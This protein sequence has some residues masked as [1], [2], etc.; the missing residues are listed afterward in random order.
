MKKK[1]FIVL[2][3]LLIFAIFATSIGLISWYLVLKF[4]GGDTPN[5][6]HTHEYSVQ[7]IKEPTCTGRGYTTYVCECGK[8]YTGDYVNA[9]GHDLGDDNICTRCGYFQHEHEYEKTVINPTCTEGGYTRG[10][11][12]YCTAGFISDRTDALGHDFIDSVCTR[13]GEMSPTDGLI[14]ELSKDG[15]YYICTG[16]NPDLKSL[17]IASVYNSKP[18]KEIGSSAFDYCSLESVII[19]NGITVIGHGAF[20]CCRSLK[21]VTIPNSVTHI[22]GIAFNCCEELTE[23]NYKGTIAQWNAIEKHSSWDMDTGNYTVHCT[24]GDIAKDVEA[25]VNKDKLRYTLSDDGTYYICSGID[26]TISSIITDV[27]IAS[28]INGL[29]VKEIGASA[30]ANNQEIQYV[31]IPD[32]VGFIGNNAF[33]NCKRLTEITIPNGVERIGELAF[34]SC[35]GLTGV[36]LGNGLKYIG[37]NAFANCIS[38]TNVIIPESV[39]TIGDS[40]FTNCTTLSEVEIGNGVTSIGNAAFR[41]CN[42]KNIIIPDSVT[43]INDYAFYGCSK[44]ESITIPGGVTNFSSYTFTACPRLTDITFKGTMDKWQS[45]RGSS[46]L[47]MATTCTVHCT[48]G[49]LT[50]NKR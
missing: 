9:L 11:C 40:A 22:N 42:I 24:D 49:D 19:P 13:C 15:T 4:K 27:N 35:P 20:T 21:S 16:G 34:A 44:L 2:T 3:S 50:L 36:K 33:S 32:S 23:I 17:I 46:W 37:G 29:P 48:D 26:P 18:V 30:F 10:E 39:I 45:I 28:D 6:I 5:E 43:K 14:Y 41:E 12:K 8:S 1:L 38:L 25:T 31:T 7:S 47:Y